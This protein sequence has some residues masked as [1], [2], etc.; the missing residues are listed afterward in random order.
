[1]SI[2]QRPD[3]VD[4]RETAG[5]WESDSIVGGD[6]KSGLNVVVE[7]STRM[8]NISLMNNKTAKETKQPAK[9]VF[10]LPYTLRSV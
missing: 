6:R 7:R 10:K 9:K 2:T 8:V 1:M 3:E 5:H 4:T